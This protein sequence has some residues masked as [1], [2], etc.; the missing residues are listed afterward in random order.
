MARRVV[1]LAALALAAM[2][3][4]VALAQVLFAGGTFPAASG[5]G[6][7]VGSY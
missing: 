1:V 4:A 7:S 2:V 6:G 5:G 3:P